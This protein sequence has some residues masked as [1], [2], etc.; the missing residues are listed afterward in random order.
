MDFVRVTWPSGIVDYFEDL[1]VNQHITIVEGTGILSSDSASFAVFSMYPNPASELV[2]LNFPS[3]AER[4][5]VVLDVTGKVVISEEIFGNT[6]QMD[7]S[8]ISGGVY[9]VEVRFNGNVHRKKLIKH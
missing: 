1:N 6:H 2:F 8:V 9:I 4:Q 5:L 3:E 7:L